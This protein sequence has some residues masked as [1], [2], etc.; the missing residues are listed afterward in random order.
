MYLLFL[1]AERGCG[2][3]SGHNIGIDG[4]TTAKIVFSMMMASAF[5]TGD[6]HTAVTYTRYYVTK[7]THTLNTHTHILSKILLTLLYF[8]LDILR[9]IYIRVP[10]T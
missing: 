9:S 6:H 7:H 2:V 1:F 8:F 3:S 4:C 10:A 5:Q